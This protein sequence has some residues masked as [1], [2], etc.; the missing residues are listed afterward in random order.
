MLKY[1]PQYADD[2]TLKAFGN[3]SY[4][5]KLFSQFPYSAS[6]KRNTAALQLLP[7][8]K[9]KHIREQETGC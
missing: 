7:P 4:E 8:R 3:S 5:I 9:D 2:F 1:E 6:P